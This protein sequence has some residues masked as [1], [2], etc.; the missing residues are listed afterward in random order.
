MKRIYLVPLFL[1][2]TSCASVI[3]GRHES[4]EVT[5]TPAGADATLVCPRSR[6]HGVTPTRL[7]LRRNAGDCTLTVSKDGFRSAE[8]LIEQGV[9]PVYWANFAALPLGLSIIFDHTD[10]IGSGAAAGVA[11]AVMGGG[12][13]IDWATGAIHKHR[14]GAVEVTLRPADNQ[15]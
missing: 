12:W 10:Q 5:S 9:N 1:C 14:P 6:N 2:L 13:L 15:K 7:T 11:Y 8:Q 3:S 4:I